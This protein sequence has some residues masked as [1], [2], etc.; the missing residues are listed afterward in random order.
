[1]VKLTQKGS[2]CYST[3]DQR[4]LSAMRLYEEDINQL[5][6]VFEESDGEGSEIRMDKEH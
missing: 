2:Q 6:L 1:M 4:P 5:V 3:V